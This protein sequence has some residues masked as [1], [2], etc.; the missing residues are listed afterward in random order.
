MAELY[1][2]EFA[3]YAEQARPGLRRTAFRLTAD[4][5]EADDLAQRTLIALH[6]RWP[7]LRDHDRLAGYAHTIMVRLLIS[8]RR[9]HRWS[10]EILAERLPEP[11]PEPDHSADLGDRILLLRALAELSP[12]QREAIILRYW[13]DRSV[14]ETAAEL[15]CMQST[16]R[17]QTAR[18]LATLR[19]ALEAADKGISGDA[20]A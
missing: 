19:S 13:E 3:R 11:A 5:H 9:A 2:D 6:A 10:S 1:E 15:G 14:A 18:A 20:P 17:S 7:S 12:R 4:W 16:V 8:D